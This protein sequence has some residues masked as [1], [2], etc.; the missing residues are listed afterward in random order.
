[1]TE[2]NIASGHMCDQCGDVGFNHLE[3]L[4]THRR[5]YCKKRKSLEDTK[6]RDSGEAREDA[7]MVKSEGVARKSSK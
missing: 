6:R 5:D 3:N 4:N 1:M 7:P 2:Q